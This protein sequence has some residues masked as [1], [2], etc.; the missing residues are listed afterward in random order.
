MRWISDSFFNYIHQI[1]RSNEG[2]HPL[3]PQEK[4]ALYFSGRAHGHG[5][6]GAYDYI[7]F[8]QF[9]SKKD[10]ISFI[11]ANRNNFSPEKRLIFKT[12]V[13]WLQRF[14][15]IIYR[16][17]FSKII[18]SSSEQENLLKEQGFQIVA[19]HRVKI[20]PFYFPLFSW[21]INVICQFPFFNYFC[22][23]HYLVV[24]LPRKIRQ[25]YAV[26]VIIPCKNE[27]G[28]I[29]HA[30][31]HIPEMGKGTELIFIEGNS[32]DGTYEEL[33]RMQKKYPHRMIK[34]LKQ[35][36]RGKKEA[37]KKGFLH[38]TGEILM[39]LD[40]D[41]TVDPRSLNLFYDALKRGDGEFINGSRLTYPMEPG[42]MEWGAFLANYGIGYCISWLL[43]Q[44]VKDA[45]CGTK[46]FFASDYR[47]FLALNKLFGNL[48]PFGDFDL[49]FCAGFYNL[50]I[51]DLPIHYKSRRYGSSQ[52]SR[53]FHVW[54]LIAMGIRAIKEFK[55]RHG[56]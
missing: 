46:V 43:N 9:D 37:V 53:Y 50:K 3:V 30:V 13:P 45:L 19:K 26:S 10:I 27:K 4:N 31:Q 35:E 23:Q 40:A 56:N 47:Q 42:A 39:I 25:E 33:E 18:L 1:L 29:E 51:F 32:T 38:A 5:D 54:F 6:W 22:L 55:L 34:I 41:L 21:C 8:D 11:T 16:S 20:F 52:I 44:K 15:Q 48:D 49:L 7:I 28:N 14:R 2:G 24:R 17:L 36:G 12:H